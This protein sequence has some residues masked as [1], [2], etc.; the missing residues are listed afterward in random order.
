MKLNQLRD[1][2]AIAEHGSL[3]AAGRHLGVTQPAMTRSVRELEQELCAVLFE[4]RPKGVALT[5]AGVAF[6]RRAAAIHAELQ[7]A[8]DEVGQIEGRDIGEVT[9]GLSTASTMV[10]MPTVVGP[11][12]KRYPRAVLKIAETLFSPVEAEVVDG[13]MDLYVGPVD[14]AGVSSSLEVEH[15]FDIERLVI[16]RSGHPLGRATVLAEL[17]D[18]EWVRPAL[19]DRSTE[20]DLGAIFLAAGLPPPKVVLHARSALLTLTAVA[21]SDL[22]TILPR[23]W[24][25]FAA[26]RPLVRAI[27][28]PM[29]APP[30]CIARRRAMPLTPMAEHLS[31]LIRRAAGHYR[32]RQGQTA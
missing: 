12:R 1:V 13:R 8:C 20:G 24:V 11:F 6:L 15:L 19:S 28:A 14:P 4:R 21:E 3:R 29:P 9:I 27:G 25:E 17:H 16:G 23:P 32:D 5:P 22:L 26:T 10:L 7:R 30:I 31:D 2:L 18:A